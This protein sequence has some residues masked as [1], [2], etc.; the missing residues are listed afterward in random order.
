MKAKVYTVD[1]ANRVLGIIRKTFAEAKS[2]RV[3]IGSINLDYEFMQI[4]NES[5]SGNATLAQIK[6]ELDTLVEDFRRKVAFLESLG[7]QIK[8]FDPGIIDFFSIR[9][10]CVVLLCWREGEPSV[11]YWHPLDAGFAERQPV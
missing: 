11:R 6:T 7:V 8:Q 9:D 3:R 10:G 5:N 2:L 4:G 1:E